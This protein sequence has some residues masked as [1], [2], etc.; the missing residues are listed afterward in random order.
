MHFVQ[1]KGILSANDTMNIY[2]GCLHG[3]IYCDSRS[4]CYQMDHDFED[5]EVKINA[6][7]LLDQTLRKKRRKQRLMTGAMSDP[8]LPL[9]KE[10]QLT[11][12]CLEVIARH[13]FGLCILTKSDLILRDIDLLSAIHQKA[14]CY[15]MM[16]LTTADEALCHLVEPHVASTWRRVEVLKQ[17][18][19][20]GI[21]TIVWFSPLLPMINDTVENIEA[22]V[23]MCHEAHVEGIVSFGMG[24][25]LRAG[26]REY[27]YQKLDELFPGLRRKYEQRYGLA[28]ELKSDRQQLLEARFVALCQQY[29][30]ICDQQ[31]LWR[32]MRELPPQYTQLSLF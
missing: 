20:A 29:G 21:P 13:G 3:C 27:Y 7:L 31:E 15:V 11:R 4:L 1:A 22:I 18:H 12:Q 16:T 17:M 23:S 10:L 32:R 6:P 24:L 30:L 26:D 14:H 25:T 8:Y 2:R 28:Y 5:I 19:A 9:E